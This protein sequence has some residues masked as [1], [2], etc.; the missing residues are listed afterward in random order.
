MTGDPFHRLFSLVVF[1]APFRQT[2]LP[3]SMAPCGAHGCPQRIVPF[4]DGTVLLFRRLTP[5][6]FLPR[7]WVLASL[8]QVFTDLIRLFT[9]F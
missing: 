3:Q 2:A 6:F 7:T 4:L 5:L 8:G 9:F 1:F